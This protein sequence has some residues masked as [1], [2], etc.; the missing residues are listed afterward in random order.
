[1]LENFDS[2][3]QFADTLKSVVLDM[4]N[5]SKAKRIEAL[6]TITN[7]ERCRWHPAAMTQAI[8]LIV[9]NEEDWLS[10]LGTDEE[11]LTNM[12]AI[13]QVYSQHI[14]CDQVELEDILDMKGA[15]EYLGIHLDTMKKY[16]YRQE[17][18]RGKMVGNSMAFTR[19]QLDT[20]KRQELG[21]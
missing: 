8:Q 17:R 1:M 18:L 10:A 19:R 7:F 4:S 2:V 5:V 15:A 21:G 16:V 6:R 11:F 9:G 3:Q 12:D 14:D 20:F 13:Y